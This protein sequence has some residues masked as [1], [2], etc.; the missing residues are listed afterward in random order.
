MG[1]IHDRICVGVKVDHLCERED[2]YQALIRLKRLN[3]EN[4]NDTDSMRCSFGIT[5]GIKIMMPVIDS[6]VTQV[7]NCEMKTVTE[8]LSAM[9]MTIQF[10]TDRSCFHEQSPS[11]I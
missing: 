5:T 9:R 10:S 7:H 4:R 1:T 3:Y 11:F 8:A 2:V 6:R